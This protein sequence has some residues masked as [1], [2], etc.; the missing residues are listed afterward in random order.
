MKV[1]EPTM[2]KDAWAFSIIL[3]MSISLIAASA[4]LLSIISPWLLLIP[5]GFF[6]L[7]TLAW[8]VIYMVK[9]YDRWK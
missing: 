4:F 3:F 9:H 5:L 1:F 2:E 7:S 8:A 6:V